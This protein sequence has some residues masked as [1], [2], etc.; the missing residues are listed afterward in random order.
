M[1]FVDKIPRKTIMVAQILFKKRSTTET[2]V[3]CNF[4]G[5]VTVILAS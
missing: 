5:V 3:N 1:S 4:N 2:D